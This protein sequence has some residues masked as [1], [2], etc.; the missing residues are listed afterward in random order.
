[1]QQNIFLVQT[2]TTCQIK[3]LFLSYCEGEFSN[4]DYF[5]SQYGRIVT[6]TT[7]TVPNLSYCEE[8]LS[9]LHNFTL[10]I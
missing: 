7:V 2:Q 8:Y 9:N 6:K 10:T 1:M 5:A 4:V 3:N